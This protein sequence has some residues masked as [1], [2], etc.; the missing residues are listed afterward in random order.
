MKKLVILALVFSTSAVV[1]AQKKGDPKDMPKHDMMMDDKDMSM[2]HEMMM[3]SKAPK[4]KRGEKGMKGGMMMELSPSDEAMMKKN[5]MDRGMSAP[6]ATRMIQL[7]KEMFTIM[8]K[9]MDKPMPPAAQT[10]PPPAPKK[11]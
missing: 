10:P 11:P 3:D 5:M 2:M 9:Y 8:K 7:R 6:D 4:G 1:F